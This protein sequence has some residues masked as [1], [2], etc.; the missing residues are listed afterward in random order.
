MKKSKEA[1]VDTIVEFEEISPMEFQVGNN[2]FES[3]GYSIVK[4]THDGVIKKLKIPIKSTGVT[5]LID[6]F[7]K[8]AP[9]PPVTTTLVNPLDP[10]GKQMGLKEKKWVK[11]LDFADPVYI[12]DSDNFQ[13]ML[14]IKVVLQGVDL[15]IKGKD[16][17]V[18]IEEDARIEALKSIG[19]TSD[20]FTQI[21]NDI[22]YLTRWK[23]SKEDD[24]LPL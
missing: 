14:G 16:G 12:K 18:I 15:P 13:S 10:I 7:T 20:Q 22:N 11:M 23:E 4:V 5:E 24:F 8:N 19:I 21:A 17:N 9:T 1:N 2:V 6:R 3:K